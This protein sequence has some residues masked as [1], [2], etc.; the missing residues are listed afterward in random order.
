[1]SKR[2]FAIGDIHG[3]CKTFRRLLES[4]S[5]EKTDVVYLLGDLIDR[6]PDS[7]GVVEAVICLL[8][9]GYDIRSCLGNHEDMMLLAV[10]KGVFG[11]EL[12]IQANIDEVPAIRKSS[13]RPVSIPASK[14]P[15]CQPQ[16]V[17]T[18]RLPK[19]S[20]SGRGRAGEG[21]PPQVQERAT[22]EEFLNVCHG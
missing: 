1:M 13:R 10:H 22:R 4:L 5:L 14:L 19:N 2:R 12:F 7:K 15:A 11:R 20:L 21:N 6:G 16:P 8:A 17:G 18:G 9:D 3:C